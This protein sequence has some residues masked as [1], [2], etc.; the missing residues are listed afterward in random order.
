MNKYLKYSLLTIAFVLVGFAVYYFVEKANN[1]ATNKH[2]EAVYT[3]SMHPE[4]I[5]N[6]PGNCPICGMV[7]VKKVS[8]NQAVES[9]SIEHLLKPTDRFVVG[10]FQTTTA[11]DTILYS[12][13]NLPGI[14]A[15]DP[16]SAVNI[17]ARISG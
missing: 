7:L 11:K 14:V 12:T 9:H 2:Q 3:C 5:R 6:E 8:E 10:S 16:N 13:V 15:Y 1:S 17:A 4:I